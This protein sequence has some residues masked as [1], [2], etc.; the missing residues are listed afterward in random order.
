[1]VV[2]LVPLED[3]AANETA[4]ASGR[5][6]QSPCLLTPEIPLRQ[7]RDFRARLL[8]V[9]NGTSDNAFGYGCRPLYGER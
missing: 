4:G 5:Y 6:T 8:P 1:M 9:F 3:F 7:H 2:H